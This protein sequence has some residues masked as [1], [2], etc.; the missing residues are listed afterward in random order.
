M[1]SARKFHT[2]TL[3]ETGK[4]AHTIATPLAYGSYHGKAVTLVRCDIST[5]RKHQIRAQ[6]A[7]HGFPLLGDTAYGGTAISETQDFFLHAHRLGI[8][9]NPLGLPPEI[10]SDISTNFAKMLSICL[11]KY[12]HAV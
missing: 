11:I 12:V 1:L 5:G 8:G 6:A 4:R 2:V 7:H 3:A 9:E 10:Q